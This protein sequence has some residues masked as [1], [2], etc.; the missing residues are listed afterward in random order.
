MNKI[1]VDIH[2][3]KQLKTEI[4]CTYQTVKSAL[5]GMTKTPKSKSIRQRALELGGIEVS[6][7]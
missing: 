5:Y 2:V 6:K 4:G 1:I 3:K 7:P